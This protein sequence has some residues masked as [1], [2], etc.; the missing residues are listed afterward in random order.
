[1]AQSTPHHAWLRA[2]PIVFVLI[3]STG[4]IVARYGMP[5][6][7]PMKFLATRYALSLLCFVAWVI[8]ARVQLPSSRSQWLHLTVV[9]VLVEVPVMLSLVAIVNAAS[10]DN[11]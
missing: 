7:P 2:M 8:L 9:G 1:M 6:A 10:P 11:A 4:F 3:W 5:Y